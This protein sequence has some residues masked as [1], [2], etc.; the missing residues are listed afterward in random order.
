M[1]RLETLRIIAGSTSCAP[2][3]H[4]RREDDGTPLAPPSMH[5]PEGAAWLVWMETSGAR[6]G[7]APVAAGSTPS[8]RSCTSWASCSW[9]AAPSSSTCVCSDAPRSLAG[10]RPGP[11]I[12]S[13]WSRAG[14]RGGGADGLHDVHGPRHR[15]RGEPRLPAQADPDRAGAARERR[16]VPS[17]ALPVRRRRGTS[18]AARPVWARTAA[19]VS[20][21]CWIGD[22]LPADAERPSAV[23]KRAS[24]PAACGEKNS[25]TARS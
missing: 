11:R 10:E 14:L 12:C 24:R 8:S 21:A 25:T 5:P 4:G 6:G 9:W 17:V 18:G 3:D 16:G 1:G 20:L 22:D 15:V 13:T 19:M 7:D 2:S 23:T